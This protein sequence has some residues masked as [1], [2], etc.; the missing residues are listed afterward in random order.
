M[1]WYIV[2]SFGVLWLSLASC[3]FLLCLLLFFAVFIVSCGVWCCVVVSSGVF[4]V[5]SPV[6]WCHA[7]DMNRMFVWLEKATCTQCALQALLP[8]SLQFIS[9]DPCRPV[10]WYG[11]F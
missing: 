5:T 3:A 9:L 2:L 10:N 1:L 8:G 4:V 11:S 6:S 7:S